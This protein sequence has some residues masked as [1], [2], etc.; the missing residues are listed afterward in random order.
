MNFKVDVN[1]PSTQRGVI[2]L[3]FGV[4]GI[5]FCWLNKDVG[6]LILVFTAMT[7]AGAHGVAVDDNQEGTK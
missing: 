4:I 3:V 2:W 5:I 1:Q 7:G 6:S